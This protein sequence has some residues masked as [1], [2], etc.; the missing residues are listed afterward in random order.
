[1]TG[2]DVL[3][4]K[5]RSYC[6]SRNKG[7]D[8]GPEL[9]LRKALWSKNLRYRLR[10]KLPG[11]PD[12]VYPGVRITAAQAAGTALG[13]VVE[14][15]YISISGT[16]MATP[17]AS[18]VAALMLQANPNLTAEQVKTEM[19]A[20][21][22][23][24]GF[25]ANDQGVGR[26]DANQS[27]LNAINLVPPTPEPTPEP[28]PEPEPPPSPVPSPQPQPQPQPQPAPPAGCLGSVKSLFSKK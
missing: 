3:T 1:M 23:N 10:N 12:I 2:R 18:G 24:L 19:L 6:M 22:V 13:P 27:Y 7:F 14:E 25:D 15:G 20:A 11:K 17:H 9:I 16:S 4:K 28:E 8:T 21:A 5:Q 26:G